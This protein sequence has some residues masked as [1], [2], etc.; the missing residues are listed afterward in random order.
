[1]AQ[2][3]LLRLRDTPLCMP[4]AAALGKRIHDGSGRLI[5][6]VTDFLI[7]ERTIEEAVEAGD[8]SNSWAARP[9]YAVVRLHHRFSW[10]ARFVYLP[11]TRLSSVGDHLTMP[12]AIESLTRS[13]KRPGFQE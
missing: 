2:S 1:M 9:V 12:I 6:R 3:H 11:A 7:E 8:R 10:P 13:L 4:V 5:G